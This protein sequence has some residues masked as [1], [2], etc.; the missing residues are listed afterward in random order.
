MFGKRLELFR[1]FGFP[2]RVDLSW[3]VVAL[4]VTWSLADGFFPGFYQDLPISTY[5]WMAA[6]GTVGLFTSILLH[7]LSHALAAQRF[8]LRIRGITLFIFGGVAEMETEPPDPISEFV[9]ALAGPLASIMIAGSCFVLYLSGSMASW[10]IPVVGVLYFL[11]MINGD[12]RAH[13]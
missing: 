12:R 10:P 2:I 7:E 8:G 4:L 13:V 6:A 11:A 3:I 9:V 5:W 1:A